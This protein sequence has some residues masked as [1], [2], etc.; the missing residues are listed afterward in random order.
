[1]DKLAHACLI[2][3]ARLCRVKVRVFAHNDLNELESLLKWAVDQPQP[4]TARSKILIVTESLFSMDG[5]TAPLKSIVQL[6]ER[7][8]AWLMVDEAHATGLYGAN[9]RG[10]A[11]EMGVGSRIEIQM[12]TLSKA[13]GS[14]GGYICGSRTLIEYLVNRAR[15]FIF[16]TAPVPAASAA[17]TAAIQFVRSKEGAER[18][19]RLWERVAELSV[20]QRSD[21]GEA[22]SNV[23]SAIIPVMIGAEEA[24]TKAAS[25]LRHAGFYVPAIRYPTVARDKARLR[26]SISSAHSSDDIAKLSTALSQVCPSSSEQ[27]ALPHAAAVNA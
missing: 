11:E 18:C 4:A 1:V 6:K 10:L 5:D 3:A 24:A 15:T 25:E 23:P 16:S 21:I 13:L 22:N 26:V 19:A 17:A 27:P 14:S 12:G 9:R 7:Y 2:D 8:G 20:H